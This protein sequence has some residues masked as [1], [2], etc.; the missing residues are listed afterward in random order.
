MNT[1]GTGAVNGELGLAKDVGTKYLGWKLKTIKRFKG[2][3]LVVDFTT[4]V[5][6]DS[7]KWCKED[8]GS[9][10]ADKY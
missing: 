9:T 6:L 4:K 8:V 1:I 3:T 2:A 10:D 7:C 5:T